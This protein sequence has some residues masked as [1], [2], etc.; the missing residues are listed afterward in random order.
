MNNIINLCKK[1][2]IELILVSTPSIS[3]WTYAR[4]NGIQKLADQNGLTYIDMNLMQ[5]QL[6]IDWETDT[7]DKGDHLNYS[8][9]VKVTDWLG[10][11]FKQ[12][13]E[14]TDHRQDAAYQSWNK[15]LKRYE[16]KVSGK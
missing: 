4:H 8:G 9:A 15:D 7:R 14:F 16:K 11:Y 3:N 13:G 5:D 1:N 12:C 6:E 2:H 10:T